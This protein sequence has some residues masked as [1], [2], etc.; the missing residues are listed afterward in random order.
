MRITRSIVPNFFTLANLFM[1]FI[2]IVYISQ[3]DYRAGVFFIILAGLF[4]TLDGVMARLI[5]S[6]SE[7]GAELDSLCDAVSFGVAPAFMCY[8]IH[9]KYLGEIGIFLSALPALAG[10]IRLARFNVQLASLEDKKYFTGLPIPSSAITIISFILF[11]YIPSDWD[12]YT[13]SAMMNAIVI[14]CSLAMVSRIKYDN[15]PRPTLRYIKQKPVIFTIFLIGLILSV[16]TKGYA[17]FP[18]MLFYI[19]GSAIRHFIN[20]LKTTPEAPDELDESEAEEPT[21]FDI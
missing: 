15:L 7:F 8:Q 21:R 3:N 20:W 1:G 17:I 6:A 19:I 12:F 16:I 11:Y 10:V 9:Y 13:K 4:D 14:I 2:A 5:K 18:F